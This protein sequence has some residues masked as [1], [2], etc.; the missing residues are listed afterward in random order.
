M[1]RTLLL[2]TVTTCALIAPPAAA[3]DAPDRDKVRAALRELNEYI[4]KWEGS[5]GPPPGRP[6]KPGEVWKESLDWGWK[7]GEGGD[8]WLVFRTQG[9][10]HFSAGELRY[11]P[12]RKLYQLTVT[13]PADGKRVFEGAFTRGRLELF[14]VDP[15]TKDRQRLTLSTN[16][17]GARFIYEYAVQ[18]NGR[19]V[20]RR[21]FMVQLTREGQS[22]AARGPK[23]ECVVTG[24]LGTIAVSHNGKTYYVCCSG[25]ADAFKE[26]PE[27][28]LKEYEARKR[29]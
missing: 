20:P 8:A 19:G 1:T 14:H 28:I 21:V 11:L 29:K 2:A 17:Q 7:F 27:G 10:R 13:D 25:C 6:A 24:G 22:L 5:G 3:A 18:P 16:N 9:G 23:R 12:D 26:D 4:G 15:A